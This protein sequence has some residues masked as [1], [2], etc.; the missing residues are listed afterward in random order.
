MRH[1]SLKTVPAALFA[2]C[3]ILSGSVAQAQE[4]L[5][6]VATFSILGD[7]VRQVGGKRVEVAVLAGPGA[8]AHVFQPTP[9]HARTVAQARVL[10]AN[11]AGFEGWMERLLKSS[12]FKGRQVVASQGV[13]LLG[14]AEEDGKH[15]HGHE[16]HK[17]GH[18]HDHEHGGQ[19]SH[20]WQSVPNAILYVKNIA[21]GL[22]AADAAGCPSYERNAAA[23]TAKLQTL[24]GEIRAAWARIPQAQRKLITSHDAFG[25]YAQTY[26]VRFLA[27]QGVSTEAE[28]S[29]KGVAQLVRQIRQEGIK[30]LF[31][32]NIS[33]PRLIEQIARET[34]LKPAGAL[35]SD[36][37]SAGAPAA[38]YAD[39]MRHN[40]RLLTEAI[41]AR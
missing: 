29:A 35:Y 4:K 16:D 23:Y 21:A 15:A 19:D 11:G 41:T 9:A 3:L 12:G 18:D 32:E 28:A 22:C 1:V 24:D 33:D 38:T 26:G 36:A 7:L 20:A 17:H 37:L 39:M 30:A 40:T 5:K 8:D 13:K 10:F 6:T 2:S 27:P 14:E 25:Y 31:V 34:G